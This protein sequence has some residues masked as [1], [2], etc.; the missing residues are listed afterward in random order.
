MAIESIK[1]VLA[2]F[3]R[4]A[5]SFQRSEQVAG[6]W[7]NTNVDLDAVEASVLPKDENDQTPSVFY[8]MWIQS[9]ASNE[10]MDQVKTYLSAKNLEI[11]DSAKSIYTHTDKNG[12]DSAYRFM[13][14][15][16]DS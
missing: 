9:H 8:N 6:E 10:E 2:V 4:K 1:D 12:V 3:A 11:L 7:I 13:I 5:I 15:G 16:S 14:V